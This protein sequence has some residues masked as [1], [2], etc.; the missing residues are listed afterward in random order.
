MTTGQNGL[1]LYHRDSDTLKHFCLANCFT[2]IANGTKVRVDPEQLSSLATTWAKGHFFAD[3]P[4]QRTKKPLAI[5]LSDVLKA[6]PERHAEAIESAASFSTDHQ[7]RFRVR[8]AGEPV[9]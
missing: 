6:L 3:L 2:F 7:K 9:R 4:I 8:M 5:N 1:T